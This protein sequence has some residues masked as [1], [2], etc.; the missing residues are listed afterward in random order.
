MKDFMDELDLELGDVNITPKPK[1]SP[2][3]T[4]TD[5]RDQHK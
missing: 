2:T 1:S 4:K 3:Q 5:Q